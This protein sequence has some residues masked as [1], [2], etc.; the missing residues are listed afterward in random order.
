MNVILT[1]QIEAAIDNNA[2]S[3][4][5]ALLTALFVMNDYKYDKL[6]KTLSFSP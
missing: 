5:T 6:F 4:Y 2:M 1:K 3:I